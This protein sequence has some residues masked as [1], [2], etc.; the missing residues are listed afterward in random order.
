MGRNRSRQIPNQN[1]DRRIEYGNW[2]FN[3]P[4]CLQA[5]LLG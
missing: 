5:E 1:L 4:L 3:A 2:N